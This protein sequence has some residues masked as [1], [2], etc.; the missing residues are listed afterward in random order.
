MTTEQRNA[1][2]VPTITED[3]YH[4]ACDGYEGWCEVCGDFTRDC[5]EVDA[6]KYS[7]PQCESPDTVCGA[8]QAAIMDKFTIGGDDDRHSP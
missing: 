7:C 8:E 5:T 3:R 4:E 2:P 1:E 6:E